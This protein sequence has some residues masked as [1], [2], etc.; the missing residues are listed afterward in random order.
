MLKVCDGYLSMHR[1][2]GY[3]Q[4]TPAYTL[5]YTTELQPNPNSTQSSLSSFSDNYHQKYKEVTA[6]TMM[7]RP[8]LLL[9]Y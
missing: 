8:T 7:M 2:G 6:P 3:T 1:D 9:F 5:H 4:N